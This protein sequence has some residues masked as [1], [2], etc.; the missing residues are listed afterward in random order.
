VRHAASTEEIRN[1]YR[2]SVQKLEGKSPLGSP[3]HRGKD[4]TKTGLYTSNVMV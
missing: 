1:V 2:I 3:R 4:N